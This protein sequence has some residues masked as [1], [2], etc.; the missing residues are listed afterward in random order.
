MQSLRPTVDSEGAR[1]GVRV[2]M[3]IAPALPPVFGDRGRLQ[4]ALALVLADCV[5]RTPAG[6]PGITII[7]ESRGSRCSLLLW[8]TGRR[9]GWTSHPCSATAPA[10][11]TTA[12]MVERASRDA[13]F[14]SLFP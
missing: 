11:G 12:L 9:I 8:S 1:V 10:G 2:E 6:E 5:R 4:E 3:K 13:G 7:T 14:R